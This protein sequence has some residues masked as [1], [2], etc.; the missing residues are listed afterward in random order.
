[1]LDSTLRVLLIED[2]RG[3]ALLVERRL[4]SE[5][6]SMDSIA[7]ERAETLG[8]G[9][10]EL[11][12]GTTDVV[13]LDLNLPDSAGADT[14]RSLRTIDPTVP[15]VV[16]TSADGGD[17]PAQAFKAGAQD[18]L[19][20]SDFETC[21]LLHRYLRHAIERTRVIAENQRI[22][23][24]LGEA[25]RIQGLGVL[26]ASASLGF[27]QLIEV[28]LDHTMAAHAELGV[29]PQSRANLH[30]LEA[31]KVGLRAIAFA[32]EL[33][34]YAHAKP[35]AML[36]DVSQFVADQAPGLEAIA[37]PS[38]D[39]EWD[40]ETP[41]PTTSANP[42]ELRQLLFTLMINA[43]EAIR[44][45]RGRIRVETGLFWADPEL[46][47]TGY[48]ARGVTEGLYLRISVSNSGPSIDG[49]PRAAR[50]GSISNLEFSGNGIGLAAALGMVRRNAGW[51][52]AAHGPAGGAHF[53]VLLP[54]AS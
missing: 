39:L 30:L 52:G 26:G 23:E 14:I 8:D 45:D 13:L 19:H 48:G 49:S 29:A 36:L 4:E 9:I 42:L 18:Y 2:D 22:Q 41:G 50:P 12:K 51:I 24:Q 25:E 6:G 15:I 3:D 7:L 33:G 11:R 5:L 34:N 10:D 46:L 32:T 43:C 47:A 16:L 27:K 1:M 35:G 17:L 40:L 37:G 44:P 21:P 28:V 31:R 53:Q 20:K 38:I 54:V